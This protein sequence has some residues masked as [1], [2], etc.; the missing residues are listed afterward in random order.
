M[1]NLFEEYVK[2]VDTFLINYFKLLL[3]SA[4]EKKLVSPFIDRYI[5]VRYYNKCVYENEPKFIKRLNKELNSVA[6]DVIS[7]HKSKVEKVKNIFALFSYIMY[8]DGCIKYDNLNTLMKALFSDKNITLEYEEATKRE[9]NVLVREFLDKKVSFFNLFKANEFYLKGK[10]YEDKVFKIDLGQNC[11]LSKLYSGYAIEKAYNSEVVLENRI[12]LALV[13]VSAKILTEVLALDFS[14]NYIFDFPVSL[15]G[16]SKKIMRFLKM[17][18]S[19]LIRTKVHMKF[20]Y[21]SYKSNKKE[22]NG[23][24]NQD[25]SVCLELDDSYDM[26][27]DSLFLFSYIIVHKDSKFY[28]NIIENKDEIKTNIIVV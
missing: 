9:V 26:N 20:T 6:K 1:D 13:L 23:L 7:E 18:D 19:E 4:Y 5:N 12:Y 24:I 22:I 11:N 28:N 25:Y 27:F 8:L 14:N 3:G 21:K 16:K 10:R 17:L 2:Y 15:L